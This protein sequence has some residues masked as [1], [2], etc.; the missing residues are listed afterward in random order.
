MGRILL[1][2][3]LLFV[4]IW[5]VRGLLVTR[6]RAEPPRTPGTAAGE[7]VHCAH[8]GVLLPRGE[9]R[10]AG[11]REYCSEEHGRLGPREDR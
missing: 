3:V 4:V 11:G 10:S 7:L 8:C 9:S 6:K 1:L 2:I 5:L